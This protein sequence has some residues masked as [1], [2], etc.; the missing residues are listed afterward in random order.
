MGWVWERVILS[1]LTP[2]IALLSINSFAYQPID[3]AVT[4]MTSIG[5]HVVVSAGN[6]GTNAM[7]RSP[8]RAPTAITVGATNITDSR[9]QFS[10]YGCVVDIFAP[11]ENIL[12]ASPACHD[13]YWSQ[14]GT[15][16]VSPVLNG[17]VL[18]EG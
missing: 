12:G 18:V 6:D 16:M 5:I 8:A 15:S 7:S 13:A 14:S 2:S 9:A 10:N 4:A 3:D 1:R 17:R 11:G